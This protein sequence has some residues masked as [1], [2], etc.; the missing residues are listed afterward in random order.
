MIKRNL[1]TIAVILGFSLVIGLC[2]FS[3]IH[4]GMSEQSA[5]NEFKKLSESVSVS[6]NS[7]ENSEEKKLSES[8]AS[9]T[10]ETM[11]VVS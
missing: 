7:S 8:N 6:T 9:A 3:V 2:L 10:S 1:G 5:D 4:T 11:P